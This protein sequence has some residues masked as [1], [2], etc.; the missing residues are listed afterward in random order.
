[1]PASALDVKPQATAERQE[2]YQRLGRKATAPLWEVLADIVTVTP[3][4][5]GVP[6]MWRY[7]ELRPLL[8]EAGGLITAHEAERRVLIL[9]NPALRGQS[10]ITGTLYAGL[11]LVLPGEVAPSHRH[12]PSALRFVLESQGGYTAV[13]GERITMRPGDFI[14]TPSWTY[15]DHGNNTN[16]PIIWLDVLD[17]PMIN[18]MAVGFAEHHPQ[19]TQPVTRPDGDSL[20]RFGSGLFPLD[21]VAQPGHSPVRVY[22][23]E[24][25]R[26][27]LVESASMGQP[28]RC[29]GVKMRYENPA[30]GGFAMATIGTF[31]QLLPKGFSGAPYRSTDATVYCVKEGH[32]KSTVGSQVFEWGPNDIF[33]VPSWTPVFHAAAETAVLFS[34]SDRPVQQ[35]LRLWR[36]EELN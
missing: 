15:H 9:E 34:A 19:E 30:S 12:T 32:G 5:V 1:M 10:Q 2:F 6:A 8:M 21:Y 35:M 31:L 24:R 23:Y 7:E 22:P 4:P 20:A 25:S 28:H 13:D 3:K 27:S 11:Q 36:E 17:L 26:A 33:V 16:A 14:V 18:S 29:H